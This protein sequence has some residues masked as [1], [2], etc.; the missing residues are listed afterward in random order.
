MA[1][2]MLCYFI[3]LHYVFSLISW[4]IEVL[5]FCFFMWKLND[6]ILISILDFKKTNPYFLKTGG[7]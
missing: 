4:I 3:N 6:V 2:L 7:T 5:D 1:G